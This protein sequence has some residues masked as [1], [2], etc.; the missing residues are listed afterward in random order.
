[1][2][3]KQK[4]VVSSNQSV[5]L[6]L[7]S[8]TILKTVLNLFLKCSVKDKTVFLLWS[9]NKQSV[10]SSNQSVVLVLNSST[11]LKT[12][13]NLFLKTSKYKQSVVSTKQLVV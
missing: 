1:M 4:S 2:V 9:Q 10:V 12:V 3:P 7:N 13:F 11:I 5:V 8:S 6:V